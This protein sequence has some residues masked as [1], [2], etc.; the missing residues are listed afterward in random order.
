MSIYLL[1]KTSCAS[2][3]CKEYFPLYLW[4]DKSVENSEHIGLYY[5]DTDLLEFSVDSNT[6]MVRRMVLTLN[7]RQCK[8]KCVSKIERSSLH[9]LIFL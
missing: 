8:I 5:E 3:E 4:F 1:S 9:T 2:V 7:K 6:K